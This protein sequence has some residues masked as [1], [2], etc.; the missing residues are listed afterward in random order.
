MLEVRFDLGEERHVQLEVSS[1]AGGQFNIREAQFE[2]IDIKG[3][4]ENQGDCIVE[5]HIMDAY[6]RPLKAENY[7]LKYTYLIGDEKWV[8]PVKVVCRDASA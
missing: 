7:I 3:D 8:D 1:K 4:V 6:I 5:E 2:L